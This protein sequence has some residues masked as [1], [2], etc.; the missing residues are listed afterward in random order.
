MPEPTGWLTLA[1]LQL[2]VPA[3]LVV[4]LHDCAPMPLP[5]VKL[6]ISPE[7]GELPAL[8]STAER[9]AVLPFVNVVGPV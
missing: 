2:A 7:I 9:V 5:R 8:V 6:I 4:P 3:A 1:M